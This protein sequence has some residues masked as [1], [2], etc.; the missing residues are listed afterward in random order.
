VVGAGGLGCPA[1]LYLA[2]SG[3]GRLTLADPDKVDLTNLQRQILYTKES[4]GKQKVDQAAA[5]LK[6]FNPDVA[7][8]VLSKKLQQPELEQLV[9]QCDVI[10]DCSDNFATRHAINRACVKHRKAL[11]SGAAMR[12]DAQLMVFDLS[13]PTSPCYSCVFPEDAEV[14]EVQ[15]SVMGV[16]A[17]LTGAIGAMQALEAIKLV[18]G[19][20]ASSNGKLQVYD[21][22]SGEWRTLKVSKDPSCEV[23]S[24]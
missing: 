23:C 8:Q 9:P 20:G 10:L 18:A 14:E 4:V 7:V 3:F 12:F 15:C 11:V 17:P 5:A 24:T 22:L 16:F 1:A 21:A 19:V 13:K 6:R 2:A